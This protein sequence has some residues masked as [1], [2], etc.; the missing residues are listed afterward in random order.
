MPKVGEPKR[1]SATQI[2]KRYN[3]PVQEAAVLLGISETTA[4]RRVDAGILRTVNDGGR[5]LVPHEAIDE[6]RQK[7]PN[8]A[9]KRRSR[10]K[11]TAAT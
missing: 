3:Y 6:Y 10:V 5:R 1:R 8:A 2:P 11:A 9:T 4:W 7:L